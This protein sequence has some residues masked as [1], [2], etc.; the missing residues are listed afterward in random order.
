MGVFRDWQPRYLQEGIATFP[1][2]FVRT[3]KGRIDKKPLVSGYLK[4]GT[5]YSSRLAEKPKFADCDG[6]GFAVNRS[7]GPKITVLDIDI[8][9]EREVTKAIERHGDTPVIV[10][11][12][13]GKY[14]L[15]YR[16]NGEPRHPRHWGDDIPIDRLGNGFVVAPP[17]ISLDGGTYQFV[18]GD[19]GQIRNLPMMRGVELRNV[20]KKPLEKNKIIRGGQ[21][22]E[23]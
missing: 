3:E 13:S 16:H 14:Q 23:T 6:I 21:R 7:Y 4:I 22:N 9:D 8:A 17:S 12:A 10:Q 18:R 5:N 1:I 15:Y 19:L 20:E 2:E 11:T